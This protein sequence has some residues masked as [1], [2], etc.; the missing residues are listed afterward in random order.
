MT[1]HPREDYLIPPMSPD[2]RREYFAKNE[3]KAERFR[4]KGRRIEATLAT[5][6]QEQI[7]QG[8]MKP[9]AENQ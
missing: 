7:A 4:R 3:A 8:V 2:E 1:D 6:G 9:S 5:L